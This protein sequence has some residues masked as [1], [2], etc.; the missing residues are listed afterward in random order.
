MTTAISV[1]LLRGSLLTKRLH[2]SSRS[3][4]I[5]KGGG[6]ELHSLEILYHHPAK[7]IHTISGFSE[8]RIDL[9]FDRNVR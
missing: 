9:V 6:Q 2:R 1:M 7:K 5:W 8:R 3:G 4:T